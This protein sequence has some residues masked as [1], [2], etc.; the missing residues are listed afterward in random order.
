MM[1]TYYLAWKGDTPGNNIS[2]LAM[3]ASF[4]TITIVQL[5]SFFLSNECAMY[6]R[7]LMNGSGLILNAVA[8]MGLGAVSGGIVYGIVHSM[9]RINYN[10]Y[11][12]GVPTTGAAAAHTDIRL[13]E[14]GYHQEAVNGVLTCV[15]DIKAPKCDDGSNA[16]PTPNGTYGCPTNNITCP[17]GSKAESIGTRLY[18]RPKVVGSAYGGQSQA[19]NGE[20]TF[21]AELYK[22]G[23]LVT[24]SISK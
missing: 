22:N 6:Y 17:D 16:V 8:A 21:V 24:E 20:S 23:Q 15:P 19:V 5:L 13:C 1:F 11:L 18:C 2:Y 3:G 12:L 14:A 7:S 4:G 9:D 10:P